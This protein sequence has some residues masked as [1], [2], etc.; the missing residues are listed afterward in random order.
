MAQ[1]M[2]ST[3]SVAGPLQGGAPARAGRL[4]RFVV[5]LFF[6]WGFATVLIDT[7]IPKLPAE[8]ARAYRI[9]EAHAVQ[10]PFL[11]IA[12]V[13]SAY[14]WLARSGRLDPAMPRVSA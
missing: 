14:A 4:V 7:L 6:A 2:T 10:A 5:V 9:T 13:I 8:A 12:A 11:G 1:P 3:A